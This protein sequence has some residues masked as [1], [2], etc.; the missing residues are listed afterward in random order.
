MFSLQVCDAC[1]K[2]TSLR[3]SEAQTFVFLIFSTL[4]KNKVQR[5][6]IFDCVFR[7]LKILTVCNTRFLKTIVDLAKIFKLFCVG[8]VCAKNVFVLAQ[9]LRENVYSLAWLSMHENWLLAGWAY[10]KVILT[11]H[12]HFQSF[13]SVPLVPHSSCLLLLSLFNVQCLA[14]LLVSRPMSSVL[15]PCFLSPILWPIFHVS[16]PCLPSAVPTLTSLFLVSR[17]LSHVSVPCLPSFVPCLT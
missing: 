2:I 7:I 16:L 17:P 11:H 9:S 5:H 4:W 8:Q 10:E 14:S 6:A 1:L 15:R 3:F 12:I 13:S